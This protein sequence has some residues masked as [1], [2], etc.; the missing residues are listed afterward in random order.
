M[1]TDEP[2]GPVDA[3]IRAA[4]HELSQATPKAPTEAL[5]HLRAAQEHLTRAIDEA[6]AA[7]ILETGSTIRTAGALAGLSENAVGPR[8]A[9]TS[10]LAA[11][12]AGRGR[13]TASGVER[14]R[15]DLEQGRHRV[16]DEATEEPRPLRFR[17]RRPT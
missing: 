15:Y 5:P 4:A 17:A 16:A 11:Y 7:A 3:A 13:V 6:M 10:L 14:A 9:R 8:L 12:D 2:A 1:R